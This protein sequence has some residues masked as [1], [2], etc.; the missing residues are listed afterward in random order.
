MDTQK[1]KQR[2]TIVSIKGLQFSSSMWTEL[3]VTSGD[4]YMGGVELGKI[5]KVPIRCKITENSL[6]HSTNSDELNVTFWLLRQC[7]V[8]HTVNERPFK[9]IHRAAPSIEFILSGK[10]NKVFSIRAHCLVSLFSSCEEVSFNNLF[11]KRNQTFLYLYLG[12][13]YV[14]C[15]T[16]VKLMFVTEYNC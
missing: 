6:N 14:K 16:K 13:K 1:T 2:V 8:L 10:N 12:F 5:S 15:I 3:K 9:L 7:T 4:Y 11:P